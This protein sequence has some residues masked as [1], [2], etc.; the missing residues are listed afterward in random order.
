MVSDVMTIAWRELR[1]LTSNPW[2][3]G[4]G[5]ATFSLALLVFGIVAPWQFGR[6]WVESPLVLLS[7]AWVPLLMVSSMVVDSIAGER[8]RHTLE[9][10]LASRLPETA[11]LTGKL[12]FVVGYAIALT[13]GS[14]CLGLA[15]VNVL[16]AGEGVA[17]YPLPTLLG[18]AGLTLLGSLGVSSLGVL[19]S[20]R[21][22][23]VRQATQAMN[24]A[25]LLLAVGPVVVVRST[26]WQRLVPG[27]SGAAQ[28]A[29]LAVVGLGGLVVGVAALLVMAYSRFRRSVIVVD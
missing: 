27:E 1:E 10:L 12:V 3:W 11:I 17:W 21:A 19:V 4:S 18:A 9:T 15:T 22:S 14:L 29:V 20:L 25:V 26:D 13:G 7:W 6:S 23:T 5:V 8:E 28:T 16:Y 2:H 24:I